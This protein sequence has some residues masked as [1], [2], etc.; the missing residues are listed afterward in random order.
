MYKVNVSIDDVSPHPLSST[1]VL[2]RCYDLIEEFDD[3]KFTLFVP[4]SYWRTMPPDS[5][6]PD[7]RTPAPLQINLY[8]E[9]C[10]ELRNLPE[11]NFEIA[12]H[13]FFHGIPE[14]NNNDEF[15]NMNY[16]EAMQRFKLMF[17]TVEQAKLD[18]KFKRIFRPPAWRM[19]PDAI[20]AAKDAE[21]KILA[22]SPKQIYK[23]I[24][25]GEEENFDSIIYCTSNPPFGP[26][27]LCDK[28]EIV[29]HAC[30]WDK[31]YLD[32]QKTEDLARFLKNKIEDI[33]FCF[34]EVL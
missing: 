21:I 29:Y 4:I 10:E 23:E 16:S 2:K 5:G 6:R 8:P 7:T 17:D 19:S 24:Y 30:E 31:N 28:T 32:E 34:M 26:L 13:G 22:L 25:Q 1:R 14:Q 20:R 9:F 12:Y 3:I 33:D 27:T 18:S 15:K 11:K